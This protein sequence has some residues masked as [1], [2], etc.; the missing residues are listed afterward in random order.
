MNTKPLALWVQALVFRAAGYSKK[1]LCLIFV[2]FSAPQAF[3]W[4]DGELLIWISSNRPFHALSGLAKAFEKEIGAPVK[5]ET[6]EQIIDS[7]QSAAQSG[8]G[9]DI[10][11]WRMIGSANG[12]IQVC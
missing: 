6:Q 3:A 1:S 12:P 2:L 11:F 9:P 4:T 5:I 10:F 8:K 7:F